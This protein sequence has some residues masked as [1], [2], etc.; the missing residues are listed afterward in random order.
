VDASQF[1]N[2]QRS[3]DFDVLVHS[4]P[5]SESIGSDQRTF[6]GSEAAS[7]QGSNNYIGIKN[8]VID[9]LIENIVNAKNRKE[10]VVAGRALDRVLL[11][12]HYIIPQWY[13][14]SSNIV[15]WN[16]FGIPDIS[17]IYDNQH[18]VGIFTWWYDEVKTN[19]LK[20]KV[21]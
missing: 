14:A 12:N 19:K 15:Y 1:V 5:Q 17:P 6:W 11:H 2:R 18:R 16:K 21:D 8:P 20:N 10:L 9:S 13:K 7:T 4:Y 3:F